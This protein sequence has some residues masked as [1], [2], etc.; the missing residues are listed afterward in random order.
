MPRDEGLEILRRLEST[1]TGLSTDM[2]A[3]KA[4]M[5]TMK[6][7]IAELKANVRKLEIDGAEMKGRVS[8]LPNLIQIVG[9]MV[10][11]NATILALG[12]A[13]AKLVLV[14]R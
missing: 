13:L 14:G 5:L 2:S 3:M 7:D 6:T 10:G 8:N 1:L 11:V 4:D 9:T 12:F